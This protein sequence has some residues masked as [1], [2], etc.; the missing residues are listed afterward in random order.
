M[1]TTH[2]VYLIPGFFGFSAFG[3][4]RY[5]GHVEMALAD[6]L[7]RRGIKARIH[8]VDTLPTAS[9][10]MRAVRL[11]EAIDQT[12]SAD[13]PIHLIGHSTG[14]MDA[15]LLSAPSISLPTQVAVER[16]AARIRS[17]IGIAGPHEGT[18]AAKFFAG[19]MGQRILQVLSLATIY[20]LRFGKLPLSAVVRLGAVF[21]HLD[22]PLLGRRTFLDQLYNQLLADFTDERRVQI[23]AFLREIR[24]D[25]SLVLQLTPEGIDLF[26]A[27]AIDRPDIAYGCVVARARAPGLGALGAIGLD[28]TSLGTHAIYQALYR[29]TADTPRKRKRE[30]SLVQRAALAASYGR[31]PSRH[32]NDG[33]VPVLSQVWGHV[34]AAVDADHLDVIGHFNDPGATVPHVDWLSTGTG[35]SRADFQRTWDA[36]AAFIAE[37]PLEPRAPARNP[38]SGMWSAV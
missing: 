4:L 12:A 26:N 18:P 8:A 3:E 38:A 23:E 1:T 13:G 11:I 33:L 21:A 16:Y 25:Q 34:I 35:Y 30:L 31:I 27:S 36:V 6:A 29:I 14:A 17:C 24:S 9:I 22:G 32:A 7:H 2:D 20:S 10:R 37:Q 19:F 5:F 15:R 28:A